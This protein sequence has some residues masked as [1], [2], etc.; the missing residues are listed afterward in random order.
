[1]YLESI[2]NKLGSG[3]GKVHT[4]RTES[5]KRL[6]RAT[7]GMAASFHGMNPAPVASKMPASQFKKGKRVRSKHAEGDMVPKA[8]HLGNFSARK[9]SRS[10]TPKR[11]GENGAGQLKVAS[12]RLGENGAGQ[13]KTAKKPEEHHFLGAML[14]AA[15]AIPALIDL[16]RKK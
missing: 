11:L 14:G 4:G 6:K 7:G 8:V 15:T 12:R 1:M 2:K 3:K 13:L 16:F 9:I 5:V 10:E